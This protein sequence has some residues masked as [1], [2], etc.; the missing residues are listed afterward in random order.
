MLAVLE[1]Q[2]RAAIAEAD[3]ALLAA[4]AAGIIAALQHKLP[5]KVLA[6]A[7]VIAVF[8]DLLSPRGAREWLVS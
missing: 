7:A 5:A 1:A 8:P 4:R 6:S 2:S 3:D